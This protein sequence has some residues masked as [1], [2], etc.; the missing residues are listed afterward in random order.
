VTRT[1]DF[2]S[3]AP[4]TDWKS[5]VRGQPVLLTASTGSY[6][7]GDWSRGSIHGVHTFRYRRLFFRLAARIVALLAVSGLVEVREPGLV[8]A[9]DRLTVLRGPARTST[10][11]DFLRELS[12]RNLDRTVVAYTRD[13][14]QSPKLDTATRLVLTT[15]RLRA[16]AAI[17]LD[18]PAEDREALW[19]DVAAVLAEQ[20][21]SLDRPSQA[22]LE[23]EQVLVDLERGAFEVESLHWRPFDERAGHAA[24]SRITSALARRTAIDREIERLFTKEADQPV[25]T[26]PQFNTSRRA[27]RLA[28]GWGELWLWRLART[29]NT[30][31]EIP[32]DPGR[33]AGLFTAVL[34]SL[35]GLDD[36]SLS[37]ADR[38]AAE[39][40]RGEAT[41]GLAA[42]TAALGKQDAATR[43]IASLP[44]PLDTPV[45]QDR[46]LA[47]QAAIAA[48]P[49][50]LPPRVVPQ[51][52]SRRLQQETGPVPWP[53]LALFEFDGLMRAAETLAAKPDPAHEA[54]AV[55][56]SEETQ[57]LD[58]QVSVAVERFR[59]RYRSRWV[60]LANAAAQ[61]IRLTAR[62][63]SDVAWGVSEATRRWDDGQ[64][65]ESIAAWRRATSIAAQQG[66]SQAAFDL[67]WRAGSL[68]VDR[69]EW[70]TAAEFLLS[71]GNERHPKAAD[72]HLLA[73]YAL[74]RAAE[75]S[76]DR[77][78]WITALDA[79]L[80]RFAESPTRTD[81]L[82]QRG[83][84]AL[85]EED[86][87]VALVRLREVPAESSRAASALAGL[88][89]AY[90][91]LAQ[92]ADLA[93][94]ERTRLVTDARTTLEP[95]LES[96]PWS[97]IQI[98]AALF[99]AESA[100]ALT[101]PDYAVA[102][103]WL[104]RVAAL[105]PTAPD[106]TPAWLPRAHQLH[107]LALAG[108]GDI[109][110]A[111]AR[112][113]SLAPKPREL[114]AVLDGLDEI[115]R[116]QPAARTTLAQLQRD[117]AFELDGQRQQLSEAERNRLDRTLAEAYLATGDRTSAI[118]RYRALA[119]RQ[120]QDNAA[121][122]AVAKLLLASD[123][124]R[125][126][127]EA[128]ALYRQMEGSF[129]AGTEAWLECRLSHC[130]ALAKTGEVAAA[131]KL[132]Q[133]TRL[134]Y[135]KLGGKTLAAE[136]ATCEQEL[137]AAGK[138]KK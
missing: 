36:R 80:E 29:T 113:R 123:E 101:P 61:Q 22:L 119:E 77:R 117:A 108:R 99:L 13:R 92:A 14:L 45:L 15:V 58:Q 106:T 91:R 18:S 110:A 19:S 4:P 33:A 21:N 11:G 51:E 70:P 120:P 94:D 134:L 50:T 27:A 103:Q 76:R 8:C 40:A 118:V 23:L 66:R 7:P 93:A 116:A 59:E 96:R 43:L 17:A 49:L 73:C 138:P 111:R 48:A 136:F 1:T 137:R 85:A 131:L 47:W 88:T 71:A 126:R 32:S 129:K 98:D 52:L 100:L 135:P 112:L 122:Q 132:V 127:A 86:W 53:E 57:R 82:W 34:K 65:P 72:A 64:Y 105:P 37:S 89:T 114:L 5:V 121:K 115:A 84:A 60:E 56:T 38:T 83:Q 12:A 102:E 62:Y 3:D 24:A 44:R 25:P 124:P 95:R 79:H 6:S 41:V 67:R 31:S 75:L 90:R 55:T 42:A 20:S 109:D 130:R 9:E 26:R 104:G 28:A 54:N 128:L 2:Q 39:D 97:D 87:P 35:P 133:V 74:G 30:A 107:V 46:W 68:L 10:E 16:Q 63:G 78:A 69:E 81:A 125:D